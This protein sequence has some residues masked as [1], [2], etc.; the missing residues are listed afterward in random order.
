LPQGHF[1]LST[2]AVLSVLALAANSDSNLAS[3]SGERLRFTGQ[4]YNSKLKLSRKLDLPQRFMDREQA[5]L[6]ADLVMRYLPSKFSK[7]ELRMLPRAVAELTD[8]LLAR[9]KPTES[10]LPPGFE[11]PR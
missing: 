7:N 11:P 1:K 4:Q 9:A 5:F 8:E 3:S 6:V 2:L 10:K